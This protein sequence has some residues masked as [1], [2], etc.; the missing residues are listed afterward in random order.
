MPRKPRF[1]LPGIPAHVIQRGNSRQA[2]FFSDEDYAAYLDWLKE[3][4]EKD[5][6]ALHAD[7]LMTNHVHLLMT[8]EL[9]GQYTYYNLSQ[10]G[11]NK[12]TVSSPPGERCSET[13]YSGYQ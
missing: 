12:Y 10:C 9:R 7:V 5:G 4:A 13:D 3:G 6:C 11:V 1:Y 8:P 2:V